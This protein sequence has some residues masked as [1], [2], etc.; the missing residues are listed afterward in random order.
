MKSALQEQLMKKYNWLTP[1]D[2]RTAYAMFGFD[3]NDGWYQLL[4]D[5]FFSIDR[6]FTGSPEVKENFVITQIKEKWGALCIYYYG[7]DD[8]IEGI[9]R[10]AEEKSET[11]CEVCGKKGEL[12]RD[13]GWHTTL[14]DEHAK[15][16]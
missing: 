9:I 16:E 5:T 12:R 10:N 4:D 8:E 3:V 1:G 7:G 14:C 13:R 6:V 15:E 11:V 2:D